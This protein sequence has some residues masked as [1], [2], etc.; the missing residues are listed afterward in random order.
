MDFNHPVVKEYVAS[1]KESSSYFKMALLEPEY[2]KERHDAALKQI[3]IFLDHN[4]IRMPIPK[5]P[6]DH[7]DKSTW[8][9]TNV[10]VY[11]DKRKERIFVT[12]LVNKEWKYSKKK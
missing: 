8:K 11:G 9:Y 1:C 3:R 12:D 7:K 2:I 4:G 10:V 5:Y 6:Y